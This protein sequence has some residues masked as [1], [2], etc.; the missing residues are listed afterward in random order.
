MIVVLYVVD[1]L[2][3]DFLG[4]YGFH[5][6]TSPFID[7]FAKDGVIYENAYSTSTW[8]KA[9]AASIVTSQYP[10]SIRMMHQMDVM[11]KFESALPEILKRKGFGTYAF[12]ANGFFSPDF[13]FSGFDEFSALYKDEKL[14]S[15]RK[16]LK[17][18]NP[19]E[20]KVLEKLG[21]DKFV[22]VNSEDINEKIFPLLEKK[23]ND[24]KFIMAWSVDTHAPYF[25]RGDHSFFGNSK[26]DFIFAKEVKKKNLE[27]VKSLYFD[28][29]RYNDHHFGNLIS[30]LKQEGLYNDSL[31][32]FTADHGDSFGE[33]YLF[34]GKPIIGH[35]TIVYD[36]V[37]KV[38]LIIKYPKNE[39]AGQRVKRLAQLIDIYP[40]ILDVCQLE[41]E[42]VE[43]EGLSLAVSEDRIGDERT[44]WVE[45]HITPEH[46]YSAALIRECYKLIKIENKFKAKLN[47]RELV[48]DLLCKIQ[49][50]SIQFYNLSNDPKERRNLRKQKSD[51][52]AE[53][54]E[55]YHK[56][57][58]RCYQKAKNIESREMQQVE[59]NI[60]DNLRALGYFD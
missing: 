21:I 14:L 15:E 11:P 36:E 50:P 53:F 44:I 24:N 29:I 34:P 43:L 58:N 12:S 52:I 17:D 6:N 2:R 60:K 45:S 46:I 47:L 55:Q 26:K 20:V 27:K 1:S 37:I 22:V 19:G 32:I 10:R 8:T 35:N 25:V 9:S 59:E 54:S 28:M 56:I 7:N 4:C 48:K 13:G 31:I 5:K 57:K 30:K 38:P 49:V 3:P 33:H 51:M 42:D 18:P 16:K 23:E 39:F 40:T 41:P